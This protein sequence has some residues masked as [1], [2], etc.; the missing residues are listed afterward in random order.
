MITVAEKKQTAGKNNTKVLSPLNHHKLS[1]LNER[2]VEKKNNV[3]AKRM[4]KKQQEKKFLNNNNN[5]KRKVRR[6]SQVQE[7]PGAVVNT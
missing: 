1:S 7:Q 2:I 5:H 3:A 4:G 6:D